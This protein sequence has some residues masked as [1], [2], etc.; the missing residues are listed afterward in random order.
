[1]DKLKITRFSHA[2]NGRGNTRI[3][4]EILRLKK[5]KMLFGFFRFYGRFLSTRIVT[6]KPTA[7][8]TII[9]ATPA[10][11]Y[12]SVGGKEVTG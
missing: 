5:G 11:M 4:E 2:S 10:A 6:A 12:I 8:A 9:A 3:N 7:I 1:M